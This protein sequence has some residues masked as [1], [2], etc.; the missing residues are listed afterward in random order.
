ML[1]KGGNWCTQECLLTFRCAHLGSSVLRDGGF[2]DEK[3]WGLSVSFT[4]SSNIAVS[5][6]TVPHDSVSR[7]IFHVHAYIIH[8][9]VML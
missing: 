8:A 1:M 9:C 3:N 6:F 2:D 5:S 4:H 7:Y